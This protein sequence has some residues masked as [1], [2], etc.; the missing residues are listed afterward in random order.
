MKEVKKKFAEG[1]CFKK[2]F[3]IFVIGCIF[4]AYYEEIGVIFMKGHWEPRRGL[5]YG[6]FSPVYGICLL[7]AAI[8]F[9]RKDIKWYKAFIWC[10]FLGGILEYGLSVVQEVL[11]NSRSWDYSGYFL[12]IGGRTTGV[13]MFIWGIIGT[14]FIKIVYPFLSNL[15]EKIPYDIGQIVYV[16]LLI[17]MV[18]NI[19]ISLVANIR[20]AAR[21]KGQ[22]PITFIGEF[23]DK[24]YPDEVIQKIY[25]NSEYNN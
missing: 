16:I 1:F 15:I 18:I 21:K 8:I 6:P 19:S 17:F 5:M 23:C 13:F 7:L 9:C 10:F 11:F 20:Q 12:D 24:F 14:L 2:L 4:G 3:L 25:V 22:E